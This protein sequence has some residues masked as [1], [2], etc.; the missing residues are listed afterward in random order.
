MRVP[1]FGD[2]VLLPNELLQSTGFN[3]QA[4]GNAIQS[5][6]TRGSNWMRIGRGRKK[7]DLIAAAKSEAVILDLMSKT[8]NPGPLKRFRN[9]CGLM[10][11]AR[12]GF[13]WEKTTKGDVAS[14]NTN[15]ETAIA[16]LL[17]GVL[18]GVAGCRPRHPPPEQPFHR[19]HPGPPR[20]DP[21]RRPPPQDFRPRDPHPPDHPPPP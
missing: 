14:V 7:A 4:S 19:D 21:N 20:P 8:T 18:T 15:C 9:Y 5:T 1:I 16:L 10:K 6:M 13:P 3:L 2:L 11:V 17:L 12:S